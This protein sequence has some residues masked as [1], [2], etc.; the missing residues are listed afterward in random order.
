MK[1]QNFIFEEI[2]YIFLVGSNAVLGHGNIR[3]DF[4]SYRY[5]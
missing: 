2:K 3:S 1:E 5:A 4:S